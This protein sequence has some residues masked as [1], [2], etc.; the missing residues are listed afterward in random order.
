MENSTG[1]KHVHQVDGLSIYSQINK[2]RKSIFIIVLINI[3][4]AL[5]MDLMVGPSWLTVGDVFSSLMEGPNGDS[6]N[7]AIIWSVR[8]PVT[9]IC[10]VVGASLGLAGAQMQTILANPLA[11]PYTLGIS[12]AAGFGAALAFLTGL[13]FPNISWLNAPL[14]AFTM[15]ILSSLVIYAIGKS[16]GMQ[17]NTMVLFGI[18][19]HFFFQALQSLIQFRATPE[20]SQQIVFWMFGSLLRANWTAVIVSGSVFFIS[21]IILTRLAWQLTALSAGEERAKSLG[22]NTD[23][24]RLQVFILSAF[25]TAGAVAFVGTI[26]FIGLVA[27]HFA[28]MLVGEDQRYLAPLSA[29][30]GVL[31][32]AVASIIAKVVVPGIVVPIGIVTSLVGVPFLVY[33]I[34][35]R[36]RLG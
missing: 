26:G 10:L 22:I 28:R 31:L 30:F 11:S 32:M 18:V 6:M 4:V 5:M 12:S 8:L 33:L 19:I 29:I 24:L 34:L 2:K 1:Y 15:A 27:P 13:P 3:I 35:R 17:A 25:L 21:F 16:K 7:S 14:A 20:V 9:L 36:A 23:R